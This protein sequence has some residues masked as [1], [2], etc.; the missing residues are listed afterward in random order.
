MQLF[1]FLDLRCHSA[2]KS[3]IYAALYISL[4]ISEVFV[5]DFLSLP[6][7]NLSFLTHFCELKMT[8]GCFM[9]ESVVLNWFLYM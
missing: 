1:T 2:K 6:V 5:Y 4:A 9:G 7:G 3:K 8:R